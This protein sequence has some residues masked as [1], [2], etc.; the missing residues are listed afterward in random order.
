M[1]YYLET[2]YIQLYTFQL[3]PQSYS[4]IDKRAIMA[5]NRGTTARNT[6]AYI[7]YSS[8]TKSRMR[9][10]QSSLDRLCWFKKS[11]PS[12]RDK[13]PCDDPAALEH[14]AADNIV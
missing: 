9:L 7:S 13:L 1:P 8:G 11:S 3:I 5:I 10:A 6:I 14:D 2:S 4:S 12:L